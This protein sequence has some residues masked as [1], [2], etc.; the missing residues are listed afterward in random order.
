MTFLLAHLHGGGSVGEDS[1]TFLAP[2]YI[3]GGILLLL[4]VLIMALLSFG[5]G[6]EH[7]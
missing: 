2:Y 7:S 1:G 4:I 6:R 3:G 5:R